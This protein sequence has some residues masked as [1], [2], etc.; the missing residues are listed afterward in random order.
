MK[1]LEEIIKWATTPYI[2]GIT[3]KKI[4]GA[5]ETRSAMLKSANVLEKAWGNM[6]IGATNNNQWTT[7]LG[8]NLVKDV[9]TYY[10]GK[11]VTR[12][13]KKSHYIPD[14][15]TEDAIWEVKT[16]NWT[17]QGTAGEKVFGVPYKYSDIPDLYGKPLK[18][19][20]VAYQEWELTYGNT[21]VFGDVSDKKKDMLEYWRD[22]QI[23]FV[24]FSDLV[25]SADLV[26]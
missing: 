12:P 13:E 1:R 23:E 6:I 24:K 9:L 4:R 5:E 22:R 2:N 10:H 15:E 8:E 17:T 7:K 26:I 16:R 18:I 3:Y 25:P 19:V 20:C 11:S 21:R 14:W